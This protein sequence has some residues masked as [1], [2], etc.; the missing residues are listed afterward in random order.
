MVNRG[1]QLSATL[2]NQPA[3]VGIVV[4]DNVGEIIRPPATHTR[5]VI[6]LLASIVSKLG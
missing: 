3:H 2:F 5:K 6:Q 4:A 1:R